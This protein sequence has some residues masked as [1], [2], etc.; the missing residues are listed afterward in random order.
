[1]VLRIAVPNKGRLSEKTIETF[2]KAGIRMDSTV[3]RKLFANA[4][5]GEFVFRF[6]RADDLP[7]F[8]QDGV[9]DCGVAGL[10]S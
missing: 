2:H 3:E 7:E 4:K 9:A 8:V 10:D 5:G 6:V 1:M